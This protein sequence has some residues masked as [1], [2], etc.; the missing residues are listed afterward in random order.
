MTDPQRIQEMKLE[1]KIKL[2]L[3]L[4][5]LTGGGFLKTKFYKNWC[6]EFEQKDL[7]DRMKR[8]IK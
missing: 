6:Q 2:I 7:D 3:W 8:L 5:I 4:T 1:R